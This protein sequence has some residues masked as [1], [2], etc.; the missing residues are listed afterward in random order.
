MYEGA[1]KGVW[2]VVGDIKEFS[3]FFKKIGKKGV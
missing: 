2:T 3:N 1:I